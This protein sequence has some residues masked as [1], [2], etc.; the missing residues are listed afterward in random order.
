MSDV[1]NSDFVMFAEDV[2]T[3][4]ATAHVFYVDAVVT[5]VVVVADILEALLVVNG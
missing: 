3:Y 1:L 2:L 5:T 4:D